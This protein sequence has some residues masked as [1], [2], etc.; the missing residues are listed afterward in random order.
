MDHFVPMLIVSDIL[1]QQWCGV[2]DNGSASDIKNDTLSD[3]ECWQW[4]Q[5]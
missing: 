2:S 1:E 5:Q 4:C 3:I